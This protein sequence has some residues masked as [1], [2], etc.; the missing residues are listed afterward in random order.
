MNGLVLEGGGARGSYQIGAYKALIDNNIKIDVIVGTSIGA[1]N[2]AFLA[3]YEY[4]KLEKIWLSM[5]SKELF[6]VD[7]DLLDAFKTRK[8]TKE[9]VKNGI[10]T[11]YQIIKNSGIDISKLRKILEDNVDEE[12]LR[13]SSIDFGIVT[14]NMSKR[15]QI[16]IFKKDIP[17][18]KLAEYLIASSYL[19]I[20]KF[21][22]I[23]DDNFYVDG[24]VFNNCPCNLL[25][26]KNLENIYVVRAH[27]N[28]L[29]KYNTT[30]NIVEIKTKDKLGSIISFD[31]NTT[32]NNMLLGY[33]DTLRV[34]KNLDGV[35]YYIKYK[36]DEY[37]DNVIEDKS[38]L[39][40]LN[41][42]LLTL[43]HKKMFINVL[44]EACEY[45]KIERF[46]V[47]DI[48]KLILILKRKNIFKKSEYSNFIKKVKVKF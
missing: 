38:V 12:K 4:E 28:K 35:K 37:Y 2:A 9:M 47:Y 31:D 19:P 23:I 29:P 33:Y 24:G 5:S 25:L 45:Y 30:S 36:S 48:S 17:K 14:Y 1:I 6:G 46:K 3:S 34:L 22:K 27:S 42:N 18:G 7:Q 13:S 43:S 21:E 39:R 10:Q 16:E 8:I 40:K 26:D 20:F 11:V 15:K 44:E 41:T 32:K